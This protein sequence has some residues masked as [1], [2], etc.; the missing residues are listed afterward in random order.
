MPEESRD[1]KATSNL[2]PRLSALEDTLK[3]DERLRSLEGTLSSQGGL[4]AAPWWRNAK[5]VTIL[6]A[7]IAAVIPV[8]TAIDGILKNSREAQKSLYE[9]QDRIRQTYLD[10]V[11]KAGIT[12]AE[13]QRIFNLLSKLKGDPEFQEWAREERDKATAKIDE[14]R[15]NMAALEASNQDLTVQLNA[16]KQKGSNRQANPKVKI[17]ESELAKANQ[18]LTEIQRRVGEKSNEAQ[19]SAG[20]LTNEQPIAISI[21]KAS[22]VIPLDKKAENNE[23]VH[24]LCTINL[25]QGNFICYL[26]G[27]DENDCYYN[28]YSK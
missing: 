1:D 28:C 19:P 24:R 4:C 16:E 23:S 7:L 15:K 10:R 14:L 2:E 27:E 6:G 22:G 8:V 11:L 3:F 26:A 21:K 17:L 20:G 25:E 9:Q 18:R 12:E 13:Q 5:T